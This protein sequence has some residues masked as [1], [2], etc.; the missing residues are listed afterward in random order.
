MTLDSEA[1]AVPAGPTAA[2]AD[3]SIVSIPTKRGHPLCKACSLPTAIRGE[4]ARRAR[5]GESLRSISEYVVNEGHVLGKDGVAGHL[6]HSGIEHRT[7]DDSP[8]VPSVL[9]AVM[10]AEVLAVWPNLA[11]KLADRCSECGLTTEADIINGSIP[12]TMQRALAA[13]TGTP[14]GELLESRCL[15]KA[16]RAVLSKAHP[17]AAR[18]LAD[19]LRSQG[20]DELADSLLF[21]ADRAALQLTQ[22][23]GTTP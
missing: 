6:K 15:A 21:L 20:A 9:L 22:P 13:S 2:L 5:A 7:G 23:Q 4:I 17:A 8:K 14:A 16:I 3:A 1:S 19:D 12:E 10:V 11:Q 18:D